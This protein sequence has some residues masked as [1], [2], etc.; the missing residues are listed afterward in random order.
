M[1]ENGPDESR[2]QA[3]DRDMGGNTGPDP[4]RE[5]VLILVRQRPRPE[6]S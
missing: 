1:R 6:V 3:E 2:F 5:Y 4:C